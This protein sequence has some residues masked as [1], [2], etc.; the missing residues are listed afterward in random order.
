MNL[1]HSWWPLIGVLLIVF[2]GK[3]VLV[4]ILVFSKFRSWRLS[5]PSFRPIPREETPPA[6]AVVLGSFESDLEGL[7]FKFDRAVRYVPQEGEAFE[8]PAWIYI[9]S[10]SR[11]MAM[12]QKV[13]LKGGIVP[14][15]SFESLLD[16]GRSVITS[17][18]FTCSSATEIQ[19]ENPVQEAP[20]EKQYRAHLEFV[21]QKGGGRQCL[22]LSPEAWTSE[23][24]RIW[25]ESMRLRTGLGKVYSV[26]DRHFAYTVTEAARR[27]FAAVAKVRVMNRNKGLLAMTQKLE[28][29]GSAT[30]GTEEE[31]EDYRK[32]TKVSEV[33]KA[34]AMTKVFLLVIS[35]T[36]FVFAFRLSLSWG[37]LLILLGV[38]TFH[39]GGHLLG[40]RIFGYK[41]LQMLSLPFLGAVA[42][43]G[44]REDVKPWQELVVLFLGPVPGFVLGLCVLM[45]PLFQ[46]LPMQHKVG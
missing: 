39:E 29:S 10:E 19:L 37:T 6:T 36:L 42:M 25:S 30:P 16:D 33:S 8:A 22:F 23:K 5:T 45:S 28:A 27:T 3:S 46:R 35:M 1:M 31:I 4:H 12:V 38:L 43:G 26:G 11:V 24:G 40:M 32:N 41:N 21:R 9:N 2:L 34:G 13:Q 18:D 20:I 14:R 44:K 15:P 7:G 17:A